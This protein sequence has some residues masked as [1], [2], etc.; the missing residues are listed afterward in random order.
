[1]DV[2]HPAAKMMVEVAKTQDKE[3]GDGTTTAVVLAGEILTK[4]EELINKDV[5]PTVIVEGYR[6]GLEKVLSFLDKIA[7][8]V[9]P[10]DREVLKKVAM[11]SVSG[12]AIAEDRAFIADL[13][14]DALMQVLKKK[15]GEYDVDLD[16]VKVEKKPGGS[17]TDSK[18]IY[19]IVLDKEVVHPDM[20][21]R[22]ENAKIALL[23][24]PL[25]I[26]KTEIDAKLNIETP[27]QMRLFME[28]EEKMLKGMVDKIVSA[29]ANV[30][31][32]QKGI[33][34]L[35][36]FFLARKGVLAVRRVKA[37]DME[38]LAKAT[39]ASIV[40]N[41]DDL[42]SD[43]LGFADSV[44]EQ[45]IEADKW[46]FI[47]G[48]KNAK[49]VT[50]LVRGGSEKIVD[51]AERSIHDALS[52]IRDVIKNPKIVAGGGAPEM[53]ASRMLREYAQQFSGKEQLALLGFAEAL[54][55]IPTALAE[56]SGLDPIDVIVELRATHEKGRT[57]SG[58]NVYSGKVEDMDKL[59][60]LE[61][62][63]VKVQALKSACE[64]A[65]MI[66][67]IDDVIAASKLKEEKEKP[68][69][70]EEEE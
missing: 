10:L 50:I 20:P 41:I 39:G 18:L 24:C 44:E 70:P 25:E 45:K 63:N 53:E 2:Q 33:D 69:K 15:D 1:M 28:E 17:L 3:V 40:T 26:E 56:N 52:V 19:G 31:I 58:V 51:E 66:L 14:I 37:S 29:G 54:E 68:Y 35:A 27:E 36:Q 38:K 47:S 13:C 4:A 34:D 32:V 21:K 12:K 7:M 49:S 16:D 46:T 59:D 57:W 9:E 61:P 8:Q 67:R 30:V 42:T 43:V 62:L 60:V 5:H 22:V 23:D 11:T 55:S 48:C 6:K 64:A 65:T